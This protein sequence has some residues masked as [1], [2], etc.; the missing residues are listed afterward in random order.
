MKRNEIYLIQ[1]G[2]LVQEINANY[3]VH[4]LIRLV[5]GKG[6]FGSMLRAIGAQ[7]E[8]TSNREACRDLSGRRLR[9]INEEKRLKAYLEKQKETDEDPEEKFMKKIGKLTSKPKAEF[10]D[11]RY[12]TTRADLT[13]NI[14]DSVEIGFKKA[15]EAKKLEQS[16]GVKRK[17]QEEKKKN[18]KKKKKSSLW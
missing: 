2:K 12:E 3:D 9:D 18:L 15:M 10:K 16:V 13:Q 8:K 17:A 14:D 4:A 1:N 11:E 7:I 6:G 5:G